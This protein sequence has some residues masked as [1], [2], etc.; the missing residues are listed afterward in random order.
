MTYTFERIIVAG[1]HAEFDSSDLAAQIGELFDSAV[2][3]TPVDLEPARAEQSLT[4]AGLHVVSSNHLADVQAWAPPGQ[5][6]WVVAGHDA[7]QAD[8]ATEVPSTIAEHPEVGAI[9]TLLALAGVKPS[10]A[11]ATAHEIAE[12]LG[13]TLAGGGTQ[14]WFENRD[15]V[16]E[17]RRRALARMGGRSLAVASATERPLLGLDSTL[18]MSNDGQPIDVVG[19]QTLRALTRFYATFSEIGESEQLVQAGAS[20][21]RRVGSGGGLGIGAL[22]LGLRGQLAGLPQV[23]ADAYRL[24]DLI[25]ESD[26]VIGII[27]TLHP[28]TIADSPIRMLGDYAAEAAAPLIVFTHETSLSNHELSEWGIHQAYVV[29]RESARSDVARILTGTWIRR[30]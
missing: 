21:A 4:R 30:R 5:T 7:P 14:V 10:F 29:G 22:A 13:A 12:Q 11:F 6:T 24:S 1:E 3:A 16:D 2:H 28:Q 18:A 8:P 17:M 23:L 27:D 19:P 25:E 9:G 26:L 20:Y 15:L